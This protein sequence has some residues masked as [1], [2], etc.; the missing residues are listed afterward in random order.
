MNTDQGRNP[1]QQ[2]SLNG[3]NGEDGPSDVLTTDAEALSLEL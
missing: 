2:Y 1:N 3:D